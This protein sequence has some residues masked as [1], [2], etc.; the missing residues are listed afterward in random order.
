M[1]RLTTLS[2]ALP[3]ATSTTSTRAFSITTRRMAEGDTGSARSGGA[4]SGDAF[5]KREQANEDFYVKKAERE[6]LDALKKKIQDSE[7]ALAKD[8][9]EAAKLSS[10][11][12]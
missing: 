7:A 9:E 5:T 10:Q 12:K 4:A 6:K 11:Q 1:Y 2:R 8:K 3:R